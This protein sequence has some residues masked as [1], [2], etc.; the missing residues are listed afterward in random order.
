MCDFTVL[1]IIWHVYGVFLMQT[2]AQ[3]PQAQAWRAANRTAVA[4]LEARG[5]RMQRMTVVF[6]TSAAK[7][8]PTTWYGCLPNPLPQSY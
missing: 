5:T 3:E 8:C 1:L 2:V 7:V 4:R 6:V